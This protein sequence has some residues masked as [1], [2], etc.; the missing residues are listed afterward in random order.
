MNHGALH[1]TLPPGWLER[2]LYAVASERRMPNKGLRETNLLSLSYGRIVRKNI[3]SSDG[4]LPASF[5]TYQIVEPGDV[6]LR[7]TDLQNDQ[8]S[9]RSGLVAERGII[10]SAYLALRLQG[11]DSRFIAYQLRAIDAMKIFY[12]MGGGLRQSIGYGDLKRLPLA[13]P[14]VHE[15]RAIADY[16]DR[17]TAQID[18]FIAKNEELIAQIEERRSAFIDFEITGGRRRAQ[19][20]Q[21][22]RWFGELPGEWRSLPVKGVARRVTDGAHISPETDG[23]IF[24]FV[25]TRD[26]TDGQIDF[27]GS[28]KTSAD[29]YSYMVRTGCRPFR[30][31]VLYS[32]DGTIGATAVVQEDR[33]FVVASSLVII[34]PKRDVVH[35]KYLRFALSARPTIEQARTLVRGAGLPRLSVA[36]LGRVVI[37]V[38]PIEEQLRIVAQIDSVVGTTTRAVRTARRAIEFARERRAV[39]IAAAVTGKIDVGVGV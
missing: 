4:L 11:A 24:D 18:A 9:L 29:T 3:E 20:M 28:L 21:A 10:T 15:Q 39:L 5:D 8:R 22:S 32:K 12:S 6:V 1:G 23:G 16:L 30:G 7:L 25:S 14:P 2:P 35:S 19:P 37:P 31:D 17:E 26:L 34:T 38:P 27:V 36:N 13:L 33:E